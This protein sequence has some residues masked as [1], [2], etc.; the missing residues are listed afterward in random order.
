MLEELLLLL[1]YC[2]RHD[3]PKYNETIERR[4]EEIIQKVHHPGYNWTLV[5][6]PTLQ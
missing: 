2:M 5:A 1:L 6:Y 3:I 4:S